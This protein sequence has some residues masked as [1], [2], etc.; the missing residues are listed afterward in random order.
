MDGEHRHHNRSFEIDPLII[1]L[2]GIMVGAI[3]VATYHCIVV[4]L[5]NRNAAPHQAQLSSNSDEHDQESDHRARRPRRAGPGLALVELDLAMIRDDKE[6]SGEEDTC[7]VCLS[8]FD[9]GV[10]VRVLPE[11]MHYFHAACVDAWLYSH[12]NCPLCRAKAGPPADVAFAMAEFGGVPATEQ[13]R[14][15]VSGDLDPARG[16]NNEV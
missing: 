1:G 12:A 2:L 5:P 3:V 10:S 6:G 11:C 14:E 15:E 8:E 16:S 13:H 4:G 9:D 7:A